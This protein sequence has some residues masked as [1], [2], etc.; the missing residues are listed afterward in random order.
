MCRETRAMLD[1]GINPVIGSVATTFQIF[2]TD[3]S[4]F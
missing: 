2:Q 1:R 4:V 3:Y